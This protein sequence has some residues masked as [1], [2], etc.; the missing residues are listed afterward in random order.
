M[1]T[2]A[3]WACFFLNVLY[4]EIYK[5]GGKNKWPMQ[6]GDT[7][8][9]V[10][11]IQGVFR[12]CAVRKGSVRSTQ[13]SCYIVRSYLFLLL[14]GPIYIKKHNKRDKQSQTFSRARFASAFLGLFQHFINFNNDFARSKTRKY[15]KQT[16][17]R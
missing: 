15:H 17:Q 12:R 16:H 3:H 10:R 6:E 1:C 8:F 9:L 4:Y 14:K 7:P 5:N 11:S 13:K 2:K